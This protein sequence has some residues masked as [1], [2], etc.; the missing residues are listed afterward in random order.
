MLIRY[1][2]VHQEAFAFAFPFPPPLGSLLR[3]QTCTYASF[4]NSVSA[5]VFSTNRSCTSIHSSLL[6]SRSCTC[7]TFRSA[8]PSTL[9]SLILTASSV[10]LATRSYH[11]GSPG[12]CRAG[13]GST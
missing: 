10:M 8:S 4:V 12:G 5:L 7:H 1:L 2:Y 6:L 13:F 11:M 9:S 3:S